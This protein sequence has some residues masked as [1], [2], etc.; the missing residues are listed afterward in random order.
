MILELN[1]F[2]KKV[3]ISSLKE[4]AIKA[5]KKNNSLTLRTIKGLLSKI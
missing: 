3:I 5:D 2:E 4:V 1:K